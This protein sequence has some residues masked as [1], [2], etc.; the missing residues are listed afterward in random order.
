MFK[1]NTF[2][3]SRGPPATHLNA[4]LG[5][6]TSSL[7]WFF[8]K[9]RLRGKQKTLHR[10]KSRCT[11]LKWLTFPRQKGYRSRFG[12]CPGEGWTKGPQLDF[13]YP[14]HGHLQPPSHLTVGTTILSSAQHG[15]WEA[16]YKTSLKFFKPGTEHKTWM[17]SAPLSLLA[18]GRAA[19]PGNYKA[20]TNRTRLFHAV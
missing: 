15:I 8:S 14:H 13:T 20:G 16:K 2:K 9:T 6:I 19:A 12:W 7:C 18:G 4:Q 17:P 1:A 3:S 5:L 11:A 10:Q